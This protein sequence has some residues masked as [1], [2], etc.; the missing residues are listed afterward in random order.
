MKTTKRPPASIS[1]AR[2]IPRAPTLIAA[3][4]MLILGFTASITAAREA[5]PKVSLEKLEV[6]RKAAEQG[7]AQAQSILGECYAEGTGVAKDAAEAVKWFRKAAEQ[8]YASSQFFLGLCYDEGTGV[9]KD[10]AEAAKWW[11]KAAEQGDVSCQS[12]LGT[13]YLVSEKK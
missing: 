11:R 3:L 8:G 4:A 5:L 2:L 7:D 6:I 12:L 1:G 13:C 9:P 10:Q